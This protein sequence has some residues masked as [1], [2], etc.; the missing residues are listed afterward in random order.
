MILGQYNILGFYSNILARDDVENV[1]NKLNL[2]GLE[3]NTIPMIELIV[4]D[5]TTATIELLDSTDTVV[6]SPLS[7]TVTDVTTYKRIVYLGT[8]LSI[9]ECGLYSLKI[10]NGANTY[11]SDQ[12]RWEDDIDDNKDYMKVSA[13]SSNLKLGGTY[14]LDLTGI[15]FECYLDVKY[16][17]I[18]PETEGTDSSKL[19]VPSVLYANY[20]PTRAFSIAVTE[21]TFR[22]LSGLR[23]LESNGTVTVVF[24]YRSYTANDILV[25]KTNNKIDVMEIDFKFTQISE[26][27]SV[28]N[29]IS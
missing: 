24:G 26:V 14:V 5:S 10:T 7:M 4:D 19:S 15:T 21:N 2:I 8:T 23:I 11:Y 3:T 25:E 22:F 28:D 20:V 9:D 29:N 17:G 1:D 27:L 13:V 6:G 16:I 18:E 12:F